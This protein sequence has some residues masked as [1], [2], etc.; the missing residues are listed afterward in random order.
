MRP[1]T[2][3]EQANL[4]G[5]TGKKT[6]D[7]HAVP[8]GGDVITAIDGQKVTTSEGVQQAIDAHHPGDTIEITYCAQGRDQDRERQARDA[9]DADHSVTKTALE[10]CPR[11]LALGHVRFLGPS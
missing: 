8:T 11:D 3:A 10:T 1:N 7:G 6:V 5:A 2:P 9:P 4:I